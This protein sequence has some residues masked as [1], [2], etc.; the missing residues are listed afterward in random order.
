MRSVWPHVIN[1]TRTRPM[2]K[3]W[4][5]QPDVWKFGWRRGSTAYRL[6]QKVWRSRRLVGWCEFSADY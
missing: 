6:F 2:A 1:P 3:R 4:E 5:V